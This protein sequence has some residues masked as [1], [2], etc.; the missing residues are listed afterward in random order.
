MSGGEDLARKQRAKS[1]TGIYHV[2]LRGI[3]K[4]QVFFDKDDCYM[5]LNV[6]SRTKDI[7]G[8]ELY[9]YCLMK[10]H[11]HLLIKEGDETIDKIFKRFGDSFI[12]WYNLKYDRIGGVFQGRFNSAPVNDDEYFISALRY[13]H[14]NPIKAGM[15]SN[16][17]DY[18]FSSYN[19]YFM[20]NTI[21]NTGFALELIGVNEF[22]R[23][24][25]ELSSDSH[26][27]IVDEAEARMPDTQAKNIIE[28][29]SGCCSPEEFK[30]V[31][32]D[33]QREFIRIFHK[34]GIA[35][36]QIM[37]LTG[38]SQRIAQNK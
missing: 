23:I 36:R 27:D 14:Q 10:N 13:I 29:I 21:V 20:S 35:V 19:S 18:E 22:V 16:C 3:N 32:I 34:E 8:F 12:Y 26:L 25:N 2:M 38:V 7:C 15:V 37:R 4:Q 31:P 33:K 28:E 17:S 6:L 30:R 11:V 5:F 9:A 1:E 24:H